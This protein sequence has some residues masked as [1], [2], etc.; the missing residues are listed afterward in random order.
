MFQTICVACLGG[1]VAVLVLYHL[2]LKRKCEAAK[3]EKRDVHRF[4]VLERL[5][6]AALALSFLTLALTGFGA[7]CAGKSLSSWPWL[8]HWAAAPVFAAAVALVALVWTQDAVFEPHDWKWMLHL[9]GNV[10]RKDG[11]LASRFNAGQKLFLWLLSL[12]CLLLVL[13]GVTL[14]CPVFDAS[15]QRW[16]L[17]VHRYSALLLTMQFLAHV[18][19][20]I[21]A[22]PGTLWGM[23]TGYVTPSWARQHHPVWWDDGRMVDG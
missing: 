14:M 6:H 11:L 1:T 20:G 10:W 13:S 16:V 2:L 4:T 19:L 12:F 17:R 7:A 22:H 21:L 8:L 15:G 3:G 5:T 18:Y 23:I 9:G